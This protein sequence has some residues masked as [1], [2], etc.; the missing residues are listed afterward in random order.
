MIYVRLTDGLGNQMFQYAAARALA[1]R[2]GTHVSV[3]VSPYRDP[4][5]WRYYKLWYFPR[6]RLHSLPA[7]YLTQTFQLLQRPRSA[8]THV[9]TGLGF[10]PQVNC[11]P[12]WTYLRGY[13]PSE[14]YFSDNADLIRSLF[15]LS[16]FV[17]EGDVARVESLARG[18]PCVSVHVRRGDYVG[19]ELFEI[20]N[21]Q[22]F[23]RRAL[24]ETLNEA[25]NACILV[26][27]DD[28]EWCTN[29]TVVRDF[30][31]HVISG[32]KRS[33]FQDLALMA[34]C[35]HHIIPNS[36]FAW[37]AA[38]LATDP[39]KTVRLPSQWLNK[40]TTRECGLSVPGWIEIK[41]PTTDCCAGRGEAAAIPS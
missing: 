22:G 14:Q 4:R 11:L 2:R 36:T 18:R 35:R 32:P 34:S 26:F 40:W 5:N 27:S 10:D 8:P 41:I 30:D 37:W 31:A 17:L 6:L 25:G 28:P 33:A 38:W 12:D 24:R 19:N 39:M 1:E 3:D 21:L 15:D 20:G 16:A 29:W 23:Y 13:F 9:M 7:Q